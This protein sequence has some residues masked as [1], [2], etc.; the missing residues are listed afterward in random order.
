MELLIIS[1]ILLYCYLYVRAYGEKEGSTI[2]IQLPPASTK[3]G[4]RGRLLAGIG[5][6]F[7]TGA[8]CFLAIRSQNQGDYSAVSIVLPFLIGLAIPFAIYLRNK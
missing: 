2:K 4:R 8:I 5:F 7:S 3:E 6:G 1:A